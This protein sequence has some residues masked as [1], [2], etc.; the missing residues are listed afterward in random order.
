MRKSL[1]IIMMIFLVGC[2][3]K[4]STKMNDSSQDTIESETTA[5]FSSEKQYNNSSLPELSSAEKKSFSRKVMII[6]KNVS[7]YKESGTVE[8]SE[9]LLATIQAAYEM[10][11]SP[12][13]LEELDK[14]ID[15]LP[16]Q[17]LQ[18]KEGLITSKG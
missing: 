6:E 9:E 11:L 14:L 12:E 2:E 17:F 10:G 13:Q 8:N 7:V 15:Q 18:F 1:W 3:E 4:T 5:S 16:E